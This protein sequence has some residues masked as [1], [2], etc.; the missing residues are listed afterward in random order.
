MD[1]SR[2]IEKYTDYEDRLLANKILDTIEYCKKNFAYKATVFLDPRQQKLAEGILRLDRDI[3][4]HFDGG[5]QGSERQLCIIRHEDYDE[6]DIEQPYEI[7][8][9]TWYNKNTKKPTHRDF[10]GS[11]IGSGIKREM[12]GDIMLQEDSAYVICSKELSDYILYNID[13]I[14]STPVKLKLADHVEAAAED[15]KVITATVASLRLDSVIS[16]GFGI[17][18]TKA[19]ELIKSGRVRVNWEENDLTSKII[20]QSDVI[21]LRGKGRIIL[22]EIAGNTKKDRIRIT[23]KKFV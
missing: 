23:M 13:R 8:E 4:F 11:L 9:M 20:K 7:I 16:A 18:R 15:E 10:L 12:L 17:S 5:V 14:G 6:E 2:I 19:V 3:A 1:R 22:D 21:S